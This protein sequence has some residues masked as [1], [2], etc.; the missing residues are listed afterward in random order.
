MGLNVFSAACAKKDDAHQEVQA[1][2]YDHSCCEAGHVAQERAKFAPDEEAKLCV[3]WRLRLERETRRAGRE[4]LTICLGAVPSS[5]TLRSHRRGI[6][7]PHLQKPILRL[8]LHLEH[9][10]ISRVVSR[11]HFVAAL[12]P[13][14]CQ[15]G[16]CPSV[17]EI[18]SCKE[19][20]TVK[21]ME[22]LR[23][24]LVDCAQHQVAI[25][26][27]LAQHLH[28][29]QCPVR[30]E[31]RCGLVEEDDPRVSDQ[32]HPY[33]GSLALTPGDALNE[34]VA[35]VRVRAR[36]EVQATEHLLHL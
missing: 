18:A 11:R 30:V 9:D 14:C 25:S 5:S 10:E 4:H 3:Q 35:N 29:A 12:E 13:V 19:Q 32:L 15:P 16:D 6:G 27:D 17:H 28:H 7:F 20:H 8:R 36:L 23:G 22:D 34:V 33:G 21:E 26:S 2:W 1:R 31:A 24:G